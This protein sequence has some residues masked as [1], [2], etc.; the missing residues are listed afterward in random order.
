M[1]ICRA[2]YNRCAQ[3]VDNY[4]N[5]V[6]ALGI[7]GS[8]YESRVK[9]LEGIT[10]VLEEDFSCDDKD[11]F[12]TLHV[13]NKDEDNKIKSY[14]KVSGDKDYVV[15]SGY[16]NNEDGTAKEIRYEIKDENEYIEAYIEDNPSKIVDPYY[17]MDSIS[18]L[19]F[20]RLFGK[21]PS[22]QKVKTRNKKETH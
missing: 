11:D 6:S 13:F 19:S 3:L 9:H 14:I 17:V 8:G 16:K 4:D 7:N 12:F 22:Y 20:D 18:Q 21:L 10:I 5:R 1:E 15:L 2:I